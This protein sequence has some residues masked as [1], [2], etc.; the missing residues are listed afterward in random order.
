MHQSN[1]KSFFKISIFL[2]I[3]FS[4]LFISSQLAITPG[5]AHPTQAVNEA[6]EVVRIPYDITNTTIEVGTNFTVMIVIKNIVD[7]TVYDVTFNETVPAA[8]NKN[9]LI[10]INTSNGTSSNSTVGY[11]YSMILPGQQ[12]IFNITYSAVGNQPSGSV[13]FSS[14]NVSYLFSEL[15][16]PAFGQSDY[17]SDGNFHPLTFNITNSSAGLPPTDFQA[18]TDSGVFFIIGF[19]T[20][21]FVTLVVFFLS[22]FWSAKNLRN[23][24]KRT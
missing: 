21:A 24:K 19:I 6:I 9:T 16:I 2:V 22:M 23:P 11:S 15:K 8:D 7:Q 5:Q 10:I 18:T 12:K 3:N 17:Y 1:L 13:T 14:L 4:I 20:I